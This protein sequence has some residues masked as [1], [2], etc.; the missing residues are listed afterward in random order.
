MYSS[1]TV[2]GKPLHKYARA[3]EEPEEIP[4][5]EVEI[6]S[7]EKIDEKEIPGIDIAE[8]ILSK[9]ALVN[10]DFRQGEIGEEWFAFGEE[11]WKHTI[12]AF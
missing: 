10:G 12:F 11:F 4:T 1:K 3:G 8:T 7:I 6:Y 5:K 2:K 9:I